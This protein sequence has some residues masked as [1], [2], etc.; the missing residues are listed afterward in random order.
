MQCSNPK[1]YSDM[2][3]IKYI[4]AGFL[5][6][7]ATT[8]CEEYLTVN[9]RTQMTQEVL[10]NS[11][12][13][14]KD[15]LTGVYI[16]MKSNSIYGLNMTMTV[17]EQLI[18]NWD[19]TANKVDQKLGLFNYTD[20]EVDGVMTVI[21]SQEYKVISSLNAILAQIDAKK[22]VFTT[23]GLYE[24]IKGECLALRAFCHFD[25]LRL[26]GPIP[27]AVPA[28][29]SIPPYV[30][31]LSNSPN[32]LISYAQF[33]S[34]LLQDLKDAETLMKDVDPILKY[35]LLDLGR[36]GSIT[37]TTFNPTDNF[38]AY[39]YLKM[40][41]YAVKALQARANLWFNKNAD[42]LA[43][44][45]VVIAALNP[46]GT[47][48]FRLGTAADMTAKDYALINEQIFSIYDFSLY[49]K[50][51]N[52][53]ANGTLKKGTAATT[54]T[55]QLYGST[56]T[57]IREV[58][59]WVLLTQPNQAKTYILQKYSVPST[60]GTGFNDLNR[61]PMIRLSE[62]YFI[63]I[64]TTTDAAEAQSLWA[65]FRT[66]RNITVTTLP[67]D[68]AQVQAALTTEYRKEFF[69]EGQAFFAYKRLNTPKPNVLWVPAAAT[70]NY[71]IPMPKNESLSSN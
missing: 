12:N 8:S 17:M 19:V 20:A 67:T 13:G 16:Q 41:Y 30:T 52:Q 58:N 47:A 10:F 53:F 35:S 25:V 46:D 61:I 56:G 43:A 2:K 31:A 27:S 40:N 11:Q 14:F 69:G 32:P 15:A 66:A 36:P 62:M 42:A 51:N 7:L 6:L 59:L 28:T 24:L 54:V 34:L 26:W 29:N 23:P 9:P 68:P 39:R 60:P 55:S 63:A 49:T 70:P 4:V 45:K 48:K 64:E 21:Y 57:D 18:S 65:A 38:L 71:I 33:Q 1:N 5:I 37:V 50:Y 3:K 44:A 22:D